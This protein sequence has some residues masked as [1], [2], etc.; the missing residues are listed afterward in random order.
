ML[1]LVASAG[2][3]G[4]SGPTS[5]PTDPT[6][7][8]YTQYFG[9]SGDSLPPECVRDAE[10][11]SFRRYTNPCGDTSLGIDVDVAYPEL[12]STTGRLTP[13]LFLHGMGIAAGSTDIHPEGHPVNPYQELLATLAARGLVVIMPVDPHLAPGYLPYDTGSGPTLTRGTAWRSITTFEC[14]A[15]RLD[16]GT[17]LAPGLCEADGDCLHDDPLANRLA[18]SD[19]DKRNLVAI[20]HSA[21]GMAAL[22]VPHHYGQ[23]LKAIILIDPAT[24]IAPENYPPAIAPETPVIHLYPD[25]YGPLAKHE[26]NP[27]FAIAAAS[28]TGPWIPIGI[29]DYR[30]AGCSKGESCDCDPDAGC[31]ESNHCTALSNALSHSEDGGPASAHGSWCTP[32]TSSCSGG[33][34]DGLLCSGPE[35]HAC[36][37]GGICTACPTARQISVPDEAAPGGCPAGG[38][39]GQLTRCL[40]G[41][42]KPDGATWTAAHHGNGRDAS[43][44]LTRYVVAYAACFGG[45][46]GAAM[47]PWVNGEQ[48][49][50]DDAGSGEPVCTLDGLVSETCSGHTSRGRCEAAG[51]FWAQAMDGKA[52]RIN[53]GQW[54]TEYGPAT[55][56][57]PRFDFDNGVAFDAHGDF[58]EQRERLGMTGGLEAPDYNIVCRS[59]P[60]FVE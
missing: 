34:S 42:T 10:S 24:D 43:K 16:V 4:V 23:A 27:S 59:G 51:C 36:G 60:A 46:E 8:D 13:V 48:R 12:T 50:L 45:H 15:R 18:W 25:W 26:A 3:S 38:V 14:L 28:I 47:Q 37:E 2:C 1:L 9:A 22:Y 21:G 29:R 31:H 53:D 6:C 54:V 17:A 35:A 30:G 52:I 57:N 5:A 33:P 58:R 49:R 41:A 56:A 32:T 55:P 7:D 11:V 44:I 19:A 20:G 39:C 40:H